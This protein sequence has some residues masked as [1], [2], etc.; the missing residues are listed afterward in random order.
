M[1]EM[2]QQNNLVIYECPNCGHIERAE[3]GQTLNCPKCTP[4]FKGYTSEMIKINSRNPAMNKPLKP[5]PF[6]G[7]KADI[8]P[9]PDNEYFAWC[10]RCES[11]S[12]DYAT[13]K[14]AI[15]AWNR[16]ASPAEESQDGGNSFLGAISEIEVALERLEKIHGER[17]LYARNGI[18]RIKSYAARGSDRQ[19]PHQLKSCE[20]PA[21]WPRVNGIPIVT[22]P[23]ML[24][25]EW[26]LI[27][28][29]IAKEGFVQKIL[30]EL[31]LILRAQGKGDK[32]A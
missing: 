22:S 29:N 27:S 9:T 26:L 18:D 11:T 7:G 12:A 23:L 30:A 15:E 19:K 21:D 13:E 17:V 4:D 8:L 14:L 2:I 31:P 5:C 6:C 10:E 24:D 16:R 20:V 32:D 28:P 3:K 1:S 25:N